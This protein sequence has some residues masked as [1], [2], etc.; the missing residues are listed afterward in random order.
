MATLSVSQVRDRVDV[1]LQGAGFTRSRHV[2]EL[3][4]KDTDSLLPKSYSVSTPSTTLN[5]FDGRERYGDE[6][7]AITLIEVRTAYR[8]RHDDQSGDYGRALDHEH[9]VI[10][11]VMDGIDG[12]Y[13]QLQIDSVPRRTVAPGGDW[14]LSTIRWRI[15]HRFA[16]V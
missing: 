12:T 8:L 16:F 14:L 11:A 10:K 9:E 4:G 6:G 13:L 7:E 5:D 3:F 2:P 15:Y 1:A